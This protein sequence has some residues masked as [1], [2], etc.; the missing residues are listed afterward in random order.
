MIAVL[1]SNVNLKT[2]KINSLLQIPKNCDKQSKQILSGLLL[3]FLNQA[4]FLMHVF[5]KT[6]GFLKNLVFMH[7]NL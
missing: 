1:A 4:F 6:L 5:G 7:G 3:I 2:I